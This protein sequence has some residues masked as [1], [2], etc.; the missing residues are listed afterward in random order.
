MINNKSYDDRI[1]KGYNLIY[2]NEVVY[3]TNNCIIIVI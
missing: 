1:I 2:L 3:W